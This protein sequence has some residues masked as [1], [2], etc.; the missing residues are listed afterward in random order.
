MQASIIFVTGGTGGVGKSSCARMLAQACALAGAKTVLVDGNPGQ[1]SQ[2]VFL[3]VRDDQGLEDVR[4][5]SVMDAVLRPSEVNARFAF[6]PG[7]LDPFHP[8][9]ID[10]Y[11]EALVALRPNCR[12]I[13]VDAD[14][15]DP[16][17]WDDQTTFSGG[18]M[19]P[20]LASGQ[21]RLVFRIGQTGSQLDDGLAALDAIRMPGQ[22]LA[23]SQV[24]QGLKPKPARQWRQLLDGL[25]QYGGADQWDQASL[26][27]IDT[28]R[29]GWP[30]GREP[31]WLKNAMRF[32]LGQSKGKDADR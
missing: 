12:L 11:G 19:R 20:F 24:P 27:L 9:T 2:R 10:R 21:A 18:I 6:L 23:I 15:T 8:R 29:R 5:S 17:Q 31:A 26:R 30:K 22:T 13:I 16:R 7:P 4:F 14:R 32:S 28:G 1:Q 3:D 25:A